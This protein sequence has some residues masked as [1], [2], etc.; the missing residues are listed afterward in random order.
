MCFEVVKRCD[1]VRVIAFGRVR[2]IDEFETK[3]KR[4]YEFTA[5]F[6]N[7]RE[8]SLAEE[9]IKRTCVMVIDVEHMTGE[10]K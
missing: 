6:T 8:F 3:S 10:K 5:V 9:A 4:L 2:F 1:L 7:G